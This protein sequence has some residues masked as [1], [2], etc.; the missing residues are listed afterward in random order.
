MN[1][2]SDN[3]LLVLGLTLSAIGVWWL[4]PRAGSRSTLAGLALALLGSGMWASTLRFAAGPLAETILFWLFATVALVSAVL[5]ITN[6][7]PVYAALWF[8]MVT[9]STCGLFL[10]QSAPF[11]AAA[12]II[13]Y[14]G[15][16]V[17]TFVFVMMLAQQSGATIYD[18]RSRQPLAATIA[19]FVLLGALLAT[20]HTWSAAHATEPASTNPQ[21]AVATTNLLSHPAADQPI[22]TLHSLGRSLFGDY[23]FA[24]ELAGTLLLIASIGAIAMAPRRAEGRL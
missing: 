15:A 3:W 23:L 19:A 20:I 12:T 21:A 18:Q 22:G 11:L 5:M 8:A 13:V 14:A 2:L 16:I 4:M 9:L 10:L 24:V 17:V 7:N 6:R 1:W